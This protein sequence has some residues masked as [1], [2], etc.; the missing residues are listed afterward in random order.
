VRADSDHAGWPAA[1]FFS[2]I[3]RKM[4]EN[5]AR[6]RIRRLREHD[7]NLHLS[8]RAELPLCPEF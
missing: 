5:A 7:E 1:V 8:G 3:S 6:K 2:S 4:R